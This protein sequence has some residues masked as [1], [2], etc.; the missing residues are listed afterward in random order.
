M[1]VAGVD[2]EGESTAPIQVY[3]ALNVGREGWCVLTASKHTL[4]HT[5]HDH[6]VN[7]EYL[8][9]HTDSTVGETCGGEGLV[10]RLQPRLRYVNMHV[11][12]LKSKPKRTV[13]CVSTLQHRHKDPRHFL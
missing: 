4:F 8:V 7:L 10:P 12:V 6:D 5:F 11:R 2:E 13:L 9:V 1:G 3:A